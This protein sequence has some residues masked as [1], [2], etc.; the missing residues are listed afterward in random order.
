[1]VAYLV[2]L[3][4][5]A[6]AQIT[7]WRLWLLIKRMRRDYRVLLGEKI[8]L[9]LNLGVAIS[10]VCPA[11]IEAQQKVLGILRDRLAADLRKLRP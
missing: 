5:F 11:C 4:A 9:Q 8:D 3:V 2:L 6:I 10:I 7:F 1:M